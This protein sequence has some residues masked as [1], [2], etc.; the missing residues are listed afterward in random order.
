MKHL[1]DQALLFYH[2]G[3]LD[4][5]QAREVRLALQADPALRAQLDELRAL[6]SVMDHASIPERDEN[7]G[8][9]VWARVEPELRDEPLLARLWQKLTPPVLAGAA[10]VVIAISVSFYTPEI[11]E[12]PELAGT[13]ES[14]PQISARERVLLASVSK[15]LEGSQR[16]IMEF[17]NRL[18]TEVDTSEE[19][20]WAE[21]LLMANRLYRFAAEQAGQDRIAQLLADMEPVLI[22]LAN[23]ENGLSD[24]EFDALRQRISDNDL[25]F[26]MRGF[27]QGMAL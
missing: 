17:N 18:G 25:I 12:Q 23:S 16:L 13:Q 20:E 15:H 27:N 4:D 24:E 26:K 9:R 1:D 19:R 8:R 2:L 14:T 3:E 6:F 21:I 11:V 5:D 22:E 10:V 7:Y